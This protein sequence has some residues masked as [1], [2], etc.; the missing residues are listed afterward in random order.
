M[1]LRRAP[2]LLC[3]ALVAAAACRTAGS[4][5]MQPV[6]QPDGSR[7]I[8]YELIHRAR[9][10]NAWDLLREVGTNLR[11]SETPL[12]QPAA[13]RTTRGKSSVYLRDADIPLLIVDGVRMFDPLYLR[14]IP[15]SILVSIQLL[16]GIDGSTRYGLNS[17]AGVIIVTTRVPEDPYDEDEAEAGD[18]GSGR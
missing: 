17:G 9:A 3:S 14:E 5:G 10:T 11:F 1:R 4:V 13:V 12:G 15:T 18:G 8:G 16:S 2:V 7:L 6:R